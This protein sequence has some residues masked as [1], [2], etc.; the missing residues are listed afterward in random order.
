[1]LKE[2][3]PPKNSSLISD[4]HVYEQAISKKG[5]KYTE[6]DDSADFF[7]NI[8]SCLGD[9]KEVEWVDLL[10]KLVLCVRNFTF[11][12]DIETE[13]MEVALKGSNIRWHFLLPQ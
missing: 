1:M 2:F 5:S 13:L 6:Y 12:S 4:G 11:F 7:F 8:S 9:I 3:E 10:P